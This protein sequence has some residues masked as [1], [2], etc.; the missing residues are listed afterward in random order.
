MVLL[1][2]L[3]KKYYRHWLLFVVSAHI[4]LK[5]KA[6]EQEIRYAEE[7]L[8]KF[9]NGIEDL[10]GK[11]YMT[12]N[13]HTLKHVIKYVKYFGS[14]WAWS[15]FC[16]ESYNRVIKGLYHGT[17]CIIDQIF[18]G[19]FRLKLIKSQRDVFS[20]EECSEEARS[21][22][23]KLMNK[24]RIKNC[25]Q[26]NDDL[27]L[28][29]CSGY[30]LSDLERNL[31]EIHFQDIVLN[32]EKCDRYIYKNILFHSINYGRLQK[33]NNSCFITEDNK[34]F[35]VD[36]VIKLTLE[37]SDDERVVIIARK[38]EV[39]N[40]QLTRHVETPNCV[41]VGRQ[42][43]DLSIVDAS[44]I[45]RKCVYMV[46]EEEKIIVIPVVNSIETD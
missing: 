1:G 45:S 37:N 32:V 28:F 18:K 46:L 15:T 12:F 25:I 36:K 2:I 29:C 41:I 27:R 5:E 8:I 26:Y 17:Q 24:C 3:P 11:Q 44:S 30:E 13:V 42:T 14:L 16:F 31:L 4:L 40:K 34:L 38:I 10:Y 9:H 43:N 7:S 23:I 22:F 39:L 6:T 20:R 19:Y 21:L 35:I 33:R